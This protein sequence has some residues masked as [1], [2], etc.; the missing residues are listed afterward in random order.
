M[1]KQ[2]KCFMSI[3]LYLADKGFPSPNP[4][5]GAVLVKDNKII[6]KGFHKKAGMHHAEIEAI[7]SV[8]NKSKIAG[9]T[10]YVTLE[11]CSHY[12]KT[13]PCTDAILKYKI[14]KVVFAA[15]DPTKKIKGEEILKK[16]K[17]IVV[18]KVLEKEAKKQNEIFFHYSKTKKPFVAIKAASTKDGFIG[19]IHK[20]RK[21]TNKLSDKFSHKLRSKYDAILVGANTVILDNPYLTSR[22]LPYKNPLRIVLDNSLKIPPNSNILKDKNVLVATTNRADE[23]KLLFLRKKGFEVAV[24]GKNIV[25]LR[26][27]LVYLGKRGITSLLVEGGSKIHEAFLKERLANKIYLFI[28]K[29]QLRQGVL[30]FNNYQLKDYY[31]DQIQIFGSDTLNILYPKNPNLS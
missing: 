13:P 9:S 26:K 30:L 21:I 28:S 31:T 25:N 16:N 4:Y 23:R 18:S 24:L 12:G 14:K 1:K 8:K 2:E 10:L 17:I 20:T 3:A 22:V 15:K 7:N 11:P 27:L 5:V 6:G 19:C 29:K